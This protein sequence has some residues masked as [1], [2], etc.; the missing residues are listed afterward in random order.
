[1]L[2]DSII[3]IILGEEYK[4]YGS[5]L[6]SFLHPTITSSLFGPNIFLSIVFKHPQ[7]TKPSFTPMF[8]HLRMA[9]TNYNLIEKEIKRTKP[10]KK[11]FSRKCRK[12]GY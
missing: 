5:S 4:S 1:M 10:S 6:C 8:N 9:V 12:H 2:L 7:S 3:L 11:V